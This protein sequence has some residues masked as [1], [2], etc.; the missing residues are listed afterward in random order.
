MKTF[1]D[2]TKRESLVFD[3]ISTWRGG[4]LPDAQTFLN[5]HPELWSDKEVVLDLAAEEFALRRK[6]GEDITPSMFCER[7]PAVRSSLMRLV[8]VGEMISGSPSIHRAI[9]ESLWPRPGQDFLGF[10]IVRQLGRGAFARVYLADETE[11][12]GR[13]VV[14]KVAQFAGREAEILGKLNHPHVVPVYSVKSHP[15]VCLTAVCMPYLGEATLTDVLE[16]AYATGTPP[17]DADTILRAARIN[18]R[19]E[20]NAGPPSKFLARG[21]FVEGVTYLGLKIAQALAYTHSRSILHRDLKPSNVLVQPNGEPVLLDFNLSTDA[22]QDLVRAGGTVPYM[23]PE[24][25]YAVFVEPHPSAATHD[26]R[27]DV[28]ALGVI[29][30]QLL[31]GRLPFQEPPVGVPDV[32]AAER[33]LRFLRVTPAPLSTLNSKVDASLAR[34]IARCLEFN[35]A[36]RPQSV[37][38]VVSAL[39]KR[40]ASRQR[41]WFQVRRHWLTSSLT[42][43]VIV[44]A[45]GAT[46]FKLATRPAYPDRQFQLGLAAIARNDYPVALDY[47]DNARKRGANSASFLRALGLTHARLGEWEIAA[48]YFEQASHL[49]KDGITCSWVGYCRGKSGTL[50]AGNAWFSQAIALGYAPFW[51]HHNSGHCLLSFERFWPAKKAFLQALQIEPGNGSAILGLLE[52][53]ALSKG[54]VIPKEEALTWASEGE[55]RYPD[56]PLFPYYWALLSLPPDDKPVQASPEVMQHAQRAF[57]RGLDFSYRESLAYRLGISG[58]NP[59][60]PINLEAK[61][62]GRPWPL[63]IEP[64]DLP[65]FTQAATVSPK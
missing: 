2:D 33:M 39:Q 45:L 41:L 42:L 61:T 17:R 63:L 19:V 28:F 55:R 18:P 54:T 64:R 35:P 44:S 32:D 6:S 16:T 24:Q 40:L 29:L 10:R 20:L 23:A 43:A 12:G 48:K 46:G 52:V 37:E 3:V 51:V 26:P 47:L 25:L 21:S 49:E 62:R 14:V 11:L 22:E 60:K 7:F 65:P 57:D 9:D 36:D 34:L 30:Y 27:S 13:R 38:E 56:E 59:M 5:Q 4:A 58:A 31:S 1:V 8:L 50:R 15:D 53:A